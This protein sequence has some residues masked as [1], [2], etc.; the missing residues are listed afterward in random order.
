MS[1][2]TLRDLQNF[3]TTGATTALAAPIPFSEL[4]PFIAQYKDITFKIKVIYDTSF[5]NIA[6]KY[7]LFPD[8]FC[9]HAQDISDNVMLKMLDYFLSLPVRPSELQF[10]FKESKPIASSKTVIDKIVSTGIEK[11]HCQMP[12][13]PFV[14]IRINILS[15]TQKFDCAFLPATLKNLYF[16]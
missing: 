9:A 12:H 5:I 8:R 16:L 1:S 4:C 2:L 6:R 11:Q 13:A 3:G 14:I 15:E 10:T 7:R